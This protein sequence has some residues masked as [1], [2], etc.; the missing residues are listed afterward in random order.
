MTG[1]YSEY[2]GDKEDKTKSGASLTETA[3]YQDIF[4][5]GAMTQDI[6]SLDSRGFIERMGVF[7]IPVA[8]L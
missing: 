5:L 4:G 7:S 3:Y 1:Q 8:G 2:A 6:S